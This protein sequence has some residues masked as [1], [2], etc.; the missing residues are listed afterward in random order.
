[1]YIMY[2][3]DSGS[4]SYNDSSKFYVLSGAIV[5]DKTVK[6]LKQKIFDYKQLNFDGEYLDSEIH[7]HDI[8]KARKLFSRL[9]LEKKYVLLDGLYDCINE[10]DM[11]IITVG[12]DKAL[13][14]TMYPTWNVFNFAWVFLTERYDSYIDSVCVSQYVCPSVCFFFLSLS[15]LLSGCALPL[16]CMC[17]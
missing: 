3:D 11:T 8:Y 2:V 14:K 4:P 17:L 13:M 12:I 7:T 1:M 10:I 15:V 16:S 9:S 6:D 5:T